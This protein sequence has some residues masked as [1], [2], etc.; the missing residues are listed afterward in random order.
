VRLEDALRRLDSG[1]PL[2][3]RAVALTFD[4]GYRDNLE[5]AVP[6]LRSLELPAT[7]FLVP[8]LLSRET[9]PWWETVS[10]AVTN[11]TVDSFAWSGTELRT[12]HAHERVAALGVVT[13][14]LKRR[15]ASARV[16]ALDELVERLRP[17]GSRPGPDGFLDWPGAAALVRAGFDIGSHTS[18]H[19]ILGEETVERQRAEL[20]ES[21]SALERELGVAVSLL[22]YPNGTRADYGPETV[23]AAADAGYSHALTTR[24]GWNDPRTPRYE[25][26]R[27]VV[28]PER[29]LQELA[30]LSPTVQRAGRLVRR[31]GRSARRGLRRG[32]S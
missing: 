18:S 32:V 21:R 2:P 31:A 14:A 3:S 8:G 13:E 26:R 7:F 15:E 20:G 27:Y 6:L 22:A 23:A 28:Y 29:G 11:A 10:W 25:L 5:L 9:D 30:A 17:A 19:V 1:E 24:E 16:A 12:R 4:D